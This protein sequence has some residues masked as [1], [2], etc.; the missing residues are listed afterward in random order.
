MTGL[1]NVDEDTNDTIP[2]YTLPFYTAVYM[3]HVQLQVLAA[4]TMAALTTAAQALAPALKLTPRSHLAQSLNPIFC[5]LF[6][7]ATAPRSI[8][9]LVWT[10]RDAGTATTVST[11]Y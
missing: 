5:V 10:R 9:T 8:A 2:C 1:V 7:I 6:R 3:K 4:G 11:R